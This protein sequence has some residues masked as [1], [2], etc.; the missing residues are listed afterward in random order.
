MSVEQRTGFRKRI[1]CLFIYIHFV[2]L[3][4]ISKPWYMNEMA[5][6]SGSFLLEAMENWGAEKCKSLNTRMQRQTQTTLRSLI[7][8]HAGLVLSVRAVFLA[9]RSLTDLQEL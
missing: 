5:C 6:V 2:L 7:S 4:P 8:S 1:L 3:D 9:L